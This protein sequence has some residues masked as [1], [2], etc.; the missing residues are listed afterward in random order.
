MV[1]GGVCGIP[2]KDREYFPISPIG[3]VFHLLDRMKYQTDK[4]QIYNILLLRTFLYLYFGTD[5][6]QYKA[7][8][9]FRF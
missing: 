3:F 4:Q 7:I 5:I 2:Q 6:A 9:K 1:Y 8:G